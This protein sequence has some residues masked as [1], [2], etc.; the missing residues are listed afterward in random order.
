M[1]SVPQ[2]LLSRTQG[3]TPKNAKSPARSGALSGA[4]PTG[5][6]PATTGSTVQYSNQLSYG[7]SHDQPY[8]TLRARLAPWELAYAGRACRNDTP[9]GDRFARSRLV[10]LFGWG[11]PSI[12]GRGASRQAFFRRLRRVGPVGWVTPRGS[13]GRKSGR[14]VVADRRGVRLHRAYCLHWALTARRSRDPP[15]QP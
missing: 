7:A 2:W 8:H 13:P 11:G 12:G 9:R 4:T 1:S 14:G 5:L 3:M 6:E 10:I 15:L